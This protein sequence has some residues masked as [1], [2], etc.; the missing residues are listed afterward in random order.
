MGLTSLRYEEEAREWDKNGRPEPMKA[1][2]YYVMKLSSWIHSPGAKHDGVSQCLKDYLAALR[3]GLEQKNR[4]WMDDL[5]DD[6][7]YCKFCGES[8]RAENCSICTSCSTAYPPC[9]S[10]KRELKR[11]PNGNLECSSCHEG[12]IVG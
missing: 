3:Q 11:L 10:E 9:C 8:W 7:E 5:F 2:G 12:E 1:E 4:Y 6:K